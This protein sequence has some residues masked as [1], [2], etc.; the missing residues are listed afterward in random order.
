M[1]EVVYSTSAPSWP[2]TRS[3]GA[4]DR[5]VLWAV[6]ARPSQSFDDV[7]QLVPDGVLI[8]LV[9]R[10]PAVPRRRR[11]GRAAACPLE[12][13]WWRGHAPGRVRGNPRGAGAVRRQDAE[14]GLKMAT[15]VFIALGVPA[16]LAVVYRLVVPSREALQ[17]HIA[18]TTAAKVSA[19]DAPRRRKRAE[20]DDEYAAR[21]NFTI[22][23]DNGV[24]IAQ[25]DGEAA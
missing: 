8:Y 13:G 7:L 5:M 11:A 25:H 1:N 9:R 21:C 22:N 20:S 6:C 3:W 16:A 10:C 24:R 12:V 2:H 14:G 4:F 18:A 17:R 19:E 15:V 23:A